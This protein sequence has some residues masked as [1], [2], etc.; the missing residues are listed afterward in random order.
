[1]FILCHAI[2]S[3]VILVEELVLLWKYIILDV[4]II[5]IRI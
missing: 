3:C 5:N 1:M 2:P 4:R